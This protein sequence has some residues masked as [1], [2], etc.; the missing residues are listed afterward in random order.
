MPLDFT[1]IDFETANSSNAS[2][3]AVGLVRVRAGRVVARTGWLIRPPAGHDAFFDINVGIHGIRPADVARAATW[4]RQL[5]ALTAFAGTDVLVAHNAGFDMAVLRSSCDATG[6][7]VPEYRYLCSVKVSRKTYDIPSHRLPL[8]AAAAGHREFA[9][10]D[11][12]E[13]AEACAAI[14][15][16]AARRA[17]ATTIGELAA[18]HALPFGT[19]GAGRNRAAV[20]A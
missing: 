6:A 3:C 11:A 20:A 19:I 17:Q 9:H 15:I 1:A 8:A 14:I 10:H 16:D 4:T 7:E 18:A 2:A 12:T 5:P 13:D